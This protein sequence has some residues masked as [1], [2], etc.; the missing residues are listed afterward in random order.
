MDFI[1]PLYLQSG[2]SKQK[3]VYQLIQE[4][5]LFEILV[6]FKPILVGTIP[7]EIDLPE[8]D[9]DIICEV[10]SLQKFK[11]LLTE[12]FHTFHSFTCNEKMIRNE[13]SCICRFIYKNFAFEI[14]GQNVPTVEQYAFR[15]MIIEYQ[16]LKSKPQSSRDQVIALKKQGLKTEE[17]FA[18][19]LNLKGDPFEALLKFDIKSIIY[20]E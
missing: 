7:I 2:N 18:K 15:H 5:Q 4:L 11:L 16:I 19:L 3:K 17:A 20:N 9:I 1:K 6:D 8:S 14:F 10:P 13:N 12:K